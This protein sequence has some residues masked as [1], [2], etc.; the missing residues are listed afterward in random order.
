MYL[1][2]ENFFDLDLGNRQH[3][4]L[5]NYVLVARQQKLCDLNADLIAAIAVVKIREPNAC[6]HRNFDDTNLYFNVNQEESSQTKRDRRVQK[7]LLTHCAAHSFVNNGQ[8]A[9]IANMYVSYVVSSRF[10]ICQL[11]PISIC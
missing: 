10:K 5:D 2:Q 7:Q 8:F 9:V 6:H 11:F 4:Y 3:E 1:L